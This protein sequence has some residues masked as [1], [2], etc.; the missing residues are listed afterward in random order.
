M[1]NAECRNKCR[2]ARKV[3]GALETIALIC[4]IFLVAQDFMLFH[5]NHTQGAWEAMTARPDVEA[6]AFSAGKRTWHGLL[7]RSPLEGPQ[8]L[9]ILFYGNAQN[10]AV[11]LRLLDNYGAWP[12]FNDYHCLI[13]DYAGYGLNGGRPSAN[14]MRELAL[15]AYD[16]AAALE[17]QTAARRQL[18]PIH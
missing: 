4:I 10:A 2:A 3:L 11:F 18:Y 8:P 5:P 9:I 16:Y 14:N 15:A 7:R 6:V 1:Q 12:Y 13:M 17:R